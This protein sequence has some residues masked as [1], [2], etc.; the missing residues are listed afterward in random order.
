MS[1]SLPMYPSTAATSGTGASLDASVE[2]GREGFVTVATQYA[3]RLTTEHHRWFELTVTAPDELTRDIPNVGEEALAGLDER[4]VVQVGTT[5]SPG[6]L[7][8]GR[9]TP[10]EGA[11]L[12]PEEKLLRAIFGEAAGDVVDRSLRAPVG[13]FGQVTAAELDGETARVQVSWTRVLEVGDVLDLDGK[14]AMVSAIRE[15][16]ADLAVAGVGARVRVKKRELARDVLHAR[17]IGPYDLITQQPLRARDNFGGQVVGVELAKVLGAHAPWVL[18]ECFT[19]K[20][21]AVSGRIRAYESIV[22]QENPGRDASPPPPSTEPSPPT[23]STDIFSVFEKPKDGLE[24]PETMLLLA[25]WLRALGLAVDFASKTPGVEV[26]T[27]EKIRADSFGQIT[28]VDALA[29][30]KIFGPTQDYECQCGKYKRMK[31]RGT[32]CEDCGVEVIQSKVRRERFGHFE[33]STPCAG[34]GGARLEVLPVLP[35]GLRLPGS[36]LNALY[37]ELVE[38][39]TQA[40]VDALFAGLTALVERCWREGV[41]SRAV[42]YSGV[43]HLCLDDSLLK[44]TCRVPRAMLTELFKP[45]VYGVLEQ[46]GYVTTIKSAK[47]MVESGKPEAMKAVEAVSEGYPLLLACGEK[48]VMRTALPWD[49]PAIAVDEETHRVLSAQTVCVH[50]PVTTQGAVQA[51][52]LPDAPSAA[53]TTPSGWLGE[54]MREGALLPSVVRAGQSGERQTL[55]D[56]VLRCAF[57][58]PPSAIPAEELEA[59]EAERRALLSSAELSVA[60]EDG[61]APTKAP[62][63]FSRSLDELE[64][65]V[66]TSNM[67]AKA[68]LFTVGQL[69]ERTEAELLKLRGFARPHLKEVKE[70]LAEMGLSLGMRQSI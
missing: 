43:A 46:K 65:S 24:T 53:V 25:A 29:S 69:C 40:A 20:S 62:D 54:A 56:P 41:F 66:K 11:P 7:L 27:A 42:D 35:A 10:R 52:R 19:I 61:A 64:F 15:Q 60:R 47:K 2:P 37:V 18:W 36:Q 70:L 67:L 39:P 59:W 6:S 63:A 31:H 57:G 16:S 22:K 4:G 48:V 17:S 23:P 12:S 68:N 50:V 3:P 5:V 49:A 44:G 13:C 55:E 21:D 8:I 34:P 45:F 9:V 14:P 32:V 38:A 26:L 30:Q 28:E 51:L 33:L 1:D 58:R